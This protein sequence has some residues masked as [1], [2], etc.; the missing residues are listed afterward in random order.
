LGGRKTKLGHYPK[1][2]PLDISLSIPD[3]PFVFSRIGHTLLIVALL[4]ATGAH[5]AVLQSVAWTTMLVDNARVESFSAAF[6]K[7][8]DGK[9]P[10]AL[11]KKIAQGRQSEKKSDVQTELK[12]LDFF[13]QQ[14][15]FVLHS[16]AHF[17]LT[18]QLDSPA[19]LL[20]HAPPVPPPR[21]LPV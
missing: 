21:S 17:T 8:F 6:E 7:T 5:W 11:C 10:C 3:K 4:S 9:H 19:P 2:E 20:S 18:G 16:P 15:A 14:L 12:K 1:T 13:N